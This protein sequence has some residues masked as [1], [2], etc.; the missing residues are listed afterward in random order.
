MNKFVRYGKDD[1][2]D[3][4]L[5]RLRAG[6]AQ[7]VIFGDSTLRQTGRCD[8]ERLGI[9]EYLAATIA[10]PV[11]T[12][13]H[14]AYSAYMFRSYARLIAQQTTRPH[15]V[16]VPVNLRAWSPEWADKPMYR[17]PLRSA[18]VDLRAGRIVDLLFVLPYLVS[19][20]DRQ[21]TRQW[22]ARRAVSLR[23]EMLGTNGA[24]AGEHVVRDLDCSENEPNGSDRDILR[25]KF[26]WHY[27]TSA[28]NAAQMD[29]ALT[30]TIEELR[31]AGIDV[32]VYVTPVD[33]DAANHLSG[34]RLVED[35]DRRV[36]SIG[37]VARSAGANVLDLH[38]ALPHNRF[39]DRGVACE[40]LDDT[41]RRIVGELLGKK[42]GVLLHRR[43]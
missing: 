14:G 37:A 43:Q 24:L 42:I 7:V 12:I 28:Q 36:A 26:L 1:F 22:I 18:Y 40:H 38:A 41:G 23:G 13:Q 3:R 8:L 35:I 16:V 25:R 21:E 20:R 5:N 6:D 19:D 4:T 27:G 32:L 9:D 39:I 2:F 31:S 30:E 33:R 15:V 34:E 11:M 10:M 17:F 29:S